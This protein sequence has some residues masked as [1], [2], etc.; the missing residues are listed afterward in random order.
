VACGLII[1]K[2][3]AKGLAL[4]KVFFRSLQNTVCSARIEILR[5][6]HAVK[7]PAFDQASVVADA[8]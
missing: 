6:F 3:S 4:L 8:L 1:I 7:K 2:R 5:A